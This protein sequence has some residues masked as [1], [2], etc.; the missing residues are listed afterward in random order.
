MKINDLFL[1]RK[2]IL[3]EK[4]EEELFSFYFGDN[5]SLSKKY[6][7]PLR[8]DHD[9][10]CTFFY[11]DKDLIFRD[12]AKKRK[13]TLWQFVEE[14]YNLSSLDAIIKIA[15]DFK[16]NVNPSSQDILIANTKPQEKL[17]SVKIKKTNKLKNIKGTF[18]KY[19]D[20]ILNYFSTLDHKIQVCDLQKYRI[21][22]IRQAILEF[23]TSH[24][25]IEGSPFGFF[26]ALNKNLKEKQIYF[27]FNP[28]KNK[29]RQ[30]ITGGL[31][32]VEFLKEK[33]E[34]VIITKSW[35]DFFILQILGF[36]ACCI[37]SEE[38]KLTVH[39]YALLK[40]YGKKIFTLFDNDTTGKLASEEWQKLWKTI[41]LF[42][43]L[44]D[45]FIH[46]KNLG[47]VDLQDFI[48]KLLQ[49][50]GINNVYTCDYDNDT[51]SG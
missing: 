9:P 13:Y 30:I 29:F 7:N 2:K 4:S 47:K 6:T 26:Y 37:L 43:E 33:Q 27:P 22:P 15:T 42:L 19:N 50:H 48:T 49:N 12:F 39:D 41:P 21:L 24:S 18:I 3:K 44:N 40:Q 8:T 23:E 28:K 25:I 1:S 38:Y 16:I 20:E 51:T 31:F 45:S 11:G 17:P 14:K 32:G 5:I 36:N 35:K 46:Y 34:Y 10:D